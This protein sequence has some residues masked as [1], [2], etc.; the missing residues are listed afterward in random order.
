MSYLQVASPSIAQIHCVQKYI[1]TNTTYIV[2]ISAAT[3]LSLSIFTLSCDG[4]IRADGCIRLILGI[5]L[6][7]DFTFFFED[8]TIPPII[9]PANIMTERE[10]QCAHY[11][12]CVC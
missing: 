9:I 6:S 7:G 10:E 11:V 5:E 12:C 8:L 3:P 1:H 4:G 2:F